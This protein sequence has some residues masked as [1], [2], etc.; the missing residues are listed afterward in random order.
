MNILDKKYHLMKFG[1]KYGIETIKQRI[2]AK[3][4]KVKRYKNST[5]IIDCSKVT[6]QDSSKVWKVIQWKHCTRNC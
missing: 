2:L 3:A 1:F 4:N 5:N 6:N